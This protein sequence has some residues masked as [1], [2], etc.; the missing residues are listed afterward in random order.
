M[1]ELVGFLS[2]DVPGGLVMVGGLFYHMSQRGS[3]MVLR[4]AVF[5]TSGPV[6]AD[7]E[8]IQW[9]QF[10]V[11]RDDSD[12]LI[13]LEDEMMRWRHDG[14]A[15]VA[16]AGFDGRI[17]ATFANGDLYVFHM[18]GTS[19]YIRGGIPGQF[20]IRNNGALNTYLYVLASAGQDVSFNVV[21]GE[22]GWMSY[23]EY[24]G[25]LSPAIE[26]RN[27][28]ADVPYRYNNDLVI[29]TRPVQQLLIY[30]EVA[31]AR[32]NTYTAVFAYVPGPDSLLDTANALIQMY[33]INRTPALQRALRDCRRARRRDEEL[34]AAD[35]TRYRDALAAC[36]ARQ[37]QDVA[38]LARCDAELAERDARLAAAGRAAELCSICMTEPRTQT[39]GPCGH[40]YCADCIARMPGGCPECRGP[41][42]PRPLFY[43]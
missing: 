37:Q 22:E 35:A 29:L 19:Q 20:A 13:S 30:N 31:L 6:F 2:E 28:G 3:E 41:R 38:A 34:R 14:A 5:S 42:D 23:N 17:Y 21:T 27:G 18:D 40:I 36:Q 8:E 4:A 39:Y 32:T 11:Q 26:N 33:D 43:P 1:L 16:V 7:D 10:M 25:Q 24:R 9:S 12:L 15:V